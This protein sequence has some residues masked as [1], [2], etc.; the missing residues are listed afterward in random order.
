MNNETYAKLYGLFKESN[1]QGCI[2]NGALIFTNK[3]EYLGIEDS[4]FGEEIL[5][6]SYLSL[7]YERAK[8][9]LDGCPDSIKNW[10][11]TLER[12]DSKIILQ[13]NDSSNYK[14]MPAFDIHLSVNEALKVL[15]HLE[16]KM[17][18]DQKIEKILN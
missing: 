17:S 6:L 7:N 4:N 13:R 10:E 12:I 14:R 11:K 15:F 9:T 18:I 3:T 5:H 16:S 2:D 1:L 8:N